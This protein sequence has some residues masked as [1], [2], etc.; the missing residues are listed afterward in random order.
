MNR[1]EIGQKGEKIAA[2]HLKKM[3]FNITDTNWRSKNAEIDI[4]A[5]KSGEMVFVEVR[6]KTSAAFGCP[7]ESIDRNKRRKLIAAAEEYRTQHRLNGDWRIDFIGIE[8]KENG[9]FIIDHIPYAV[10]ADRGS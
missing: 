6:A 1:V 7:A 8:F 9:T 10:T 4:I 2:K 3:G 5:R